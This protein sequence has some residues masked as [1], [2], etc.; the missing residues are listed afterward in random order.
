MLFRSLIPPDDESQCYAPWNTES[1][2]GHDIEN[3]LQFI[4]NQAEQNS[5]TYPNIYGFK[6][7][8]KHMLKMVDGNA[9]CNRRW[10]R[11]ELMSGCGNW[12]IFKDDHLHYG[13]QWAHPS[14]N[15]TPGGPDVSQCNTNKAPVE[16]IK[17]TFS[18]DPNNN[19]VKLTQKF[20]YLT[21]VQGQ[22]IEST[23]CDGDHSPS[24]I[25]QGHPS[26]GGPATPYP[27]T[28][29]GTNPFFKHANECRPYKGPGTPQ[30][31][32]CD[33]PQSGIQLLS[34]SG[35]TIV[36]SDAVKEPSGKPTWE[37]SM[38]SFD[39]GCDNTFE[40]LFYIKS[41]TGHSF[42]MSDVE[43]HPTVRGE[44]NF[45][46]LKTATGNILHMNDHTEP[47]TP[48]YAGQKRGITLKST[49]NHVLQFCDSK[50]LQVGP[51]RKE[52]GAPQA[53]ATEAFVTLQ[54][55]YGH[56]LQFKDYPT[57][58]T[59]TKE[60]FIHL[61]NPQCS[62]AGNDPQCN[63]TRGNHFL[64]LQGK[65]EG[66]PG[67]VMLR[68]GG[69]HLRTTTDMDIVMVGSKEMPADKFT[70]VS[71]DYTDA[72][73]GDHFRYAG[74][75]HLFFA[76]Q[77]IVLMAGRDCPPPPGSKCPGPCV[78]SVIVSRCPVICPLTGILHWTEKA[79][80]QR[81]F[82]SAYHPCQP[83]DNC[84]GGWTPTPY[85]PEKCAE[86]KPPV[87]LGF[88]TIV[89]PQTPPNSVNVDSLG[90]TTMG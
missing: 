9:K 1:Y 31:N 50:N 24:N 73:M 90:Y 51:I 65:P 69:Y 52:G 7:P 75:N 68:C 72:T 59:E 47:K 37:R 32:S 23:N 6:T 20:P 54:S 67:I 78:Y 4:G 13:G 36:M 48:I 26:T 61:E 80:S 56:L 88:G 87:D 17:V 25:I 83:P 12:M 15:P 41:A 42:T 66:T 30:N 63:K 22:P 35:H 46:E 60:Q 3:I 81:V 85:D 21:D 45:I 28:N 77:K 70:Y 86:K 64:R 29:T 49:S 43:S 76:E 19:T 55:G 57:S 62:K 14:C 16:T 33:L 74:K 79:M 27:N 84:C 5:T 10:K 58:Q 40:G 39:F 8:E 18:D 71:K 34:I 53:Q 2:N 89:A 44:Y 11:M 38:Q 82:A